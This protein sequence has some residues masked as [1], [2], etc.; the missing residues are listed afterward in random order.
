M[1][2]KRGF[3]L[4]ASLLFLCI[5]VASLYVKPCNAQAILQKE[6]GTFS[7]FQ[8]Q[9]FSAWS[10][11]GNANWQIQQQQ[12]IA[13]QGAGTLVGRIAFADFDFQIDYRVDPLTQAS[14]FVHCITPQEITRDTAYQINMGDAPIEGF[15]PGSLVGALHAPTIQTA[16]G[17]NTLIIKSRQNRLT[18]TLN[19]VEVASEFIVNRFPSGPI[20]IRY[21]GGNLAIKSMT[22]SIPGRW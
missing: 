5:C 4:P 3:Q 19:G 8:G 21:A 13:N 9:D 10:Q 20:A 6:G 15:G 1:R 14:V 11:V 12:L 2:S 18:I 7:L 16:D 22:A 17:W